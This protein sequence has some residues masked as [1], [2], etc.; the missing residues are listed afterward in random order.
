MDMKR[1]V[2]A[3]LMSLAVA[4][5]LA[6]SYYYQNYYKPAVQRAAQTAAQQTAEDS[7]KPVQE[8]LAA[9]AKLT[10]LQR[11]IDVMNNVDDSLVC[12]TAA[13][14]LEKLDAR[15]QAAALAAL[16]TS[17]QRKWWTT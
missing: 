5:A 8:R 14:R 16:N 17:R 7:S 13:E 15:F 9:V 6:G 3:M 2:F 12:F 1:F 10:D 11:L 4:L